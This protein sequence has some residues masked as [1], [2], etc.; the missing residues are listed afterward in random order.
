MI[1]T[2]ITHRIANHLGRPPFDCHAISPTL[3]REDPSFDSLQKVVE[4]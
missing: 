4:Y 3:F 2:G 1:T